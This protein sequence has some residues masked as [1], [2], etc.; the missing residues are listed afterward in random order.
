MGADSVANTRFDS[1]DA[2]LTP[3]ILNNQ[4]IYIPLDNT[5]G[6]GARQLRTPDQAAARLS[7]LG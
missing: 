5:H 7:L 6:N 2:F 3:L 4:P 1:S